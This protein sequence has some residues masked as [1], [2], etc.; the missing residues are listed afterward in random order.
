[1]LNAIEKWPFNQLNQNLDK[2]LFVQ[3]VRPEVRSLFE[4]YSPVRRRPSRAGQRLSHGLLL[5]RHLQ[6]EDGHR[7]RILPHGGQEAAL[8]DRLRVGKSWKR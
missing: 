8:Q 4:W 1:M 7:R 5:L 2:K 3:V 6:Q